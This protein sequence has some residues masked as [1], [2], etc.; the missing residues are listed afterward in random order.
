MEQLVQVKLIGPAKIGGKWHGVGDTPS[1]TNEQLRNL[2]QAK[3]VDPS[4]LN[5]LND[6]LGDDESGWRE[7]AFDLAVLKKTEVLVSEALKP[8]EEERNDLQ[9]KL[10]AEVDNVTALTIRAETAE[11]A[12]SETKLTEVQI[13]EIRE[14]ARKSS[15]ENIGSIAAWL[16][17]EENAKAVSKLT[18]AKAAKAVSDALGREI[19]E[20]E[21]KTAVTALELSK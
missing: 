7:T 13:A 9:V 21:F 15:V 14:E 1:V 18:D 19:T 16:K 20:P 11:K 10:K 3:A 2:V 6:I 5:T 12:L 4:A 17:V 8:L